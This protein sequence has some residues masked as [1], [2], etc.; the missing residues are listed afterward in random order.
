MSWTTHRYITSRLLLCAA[1]GCAS[2]ACVKAPEQELLGPAEFSGGSD[3]APRTPQLSARAV[4]GQPLVVLI[5][6]E[7]EQGGKECR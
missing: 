7:E 4:P 6:T 1:L 3:N 2:F 5:N